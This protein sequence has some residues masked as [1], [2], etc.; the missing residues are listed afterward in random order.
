[1]NFV[2]QLLTVTFIASSVIVSGCKHT[3]SSTET[4]PDFNREIVFKDY[5]TYGRTVYF[6]DTDGETWCYY[7]L[8]TIDNPEQIKL[9]ISAPMEEQCST[10]TDLILITYNSLITSEVAGDGITSIQ[11]IAK[12]F[13]RKAMI[14]PSNGVAREPAPSLPDDGIFQIMASLNAAL[15]GGNPAMVALKLKSDN[16]ELY[17]NIPYILDYLTSDKELQHGDFMSEVGI[18][19]YA[20]FSLDDQPDPSVDVPFPVSAHPVRSEI[21]TDHPYQKLSTTEADPYPLN[22]IRVE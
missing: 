15:F 7:D 1:M 20:L 2:T 10:D 9:T 3:D 21:Y 11:T 18:L 19:Y 4:N 17:G 12:D 22:Q 14:Y 5:G 6:E 8:L 16:D 13:N